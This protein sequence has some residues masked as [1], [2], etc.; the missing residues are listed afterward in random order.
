[1]KTQYERAYA[2]EWSMKIHT[3]ELALRNSRRGERDEDTEEGEMQ[4]E[5][6]EHKRRRLKERKETYDPRISRMNVTCVP[7]RRQTPFSG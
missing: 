5:E 7:M 4:E 6:R 2:C 3:D 1:M